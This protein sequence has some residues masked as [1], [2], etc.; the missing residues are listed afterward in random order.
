[1]VEESIHVLFDESNP[2]PSGKEDVVDDDVGMLE[3][4]IQKLNIEDE[5]ELMEKKE[6][7]DE[8][9]HQ[10]EV[11]QEEAQPQSQ[12]AQEEREARFPRLRNHVDQGEI[13]GNPHD[14]VRT[15]SFSQNYMNHVAF[16]SHI[17][18]MNVEEAFLDIVKRKA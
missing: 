13:I 14:G 15:R 8:V 17:E 12:Q 9:E 3:N 10:E 5:D 16:I 11:H 18:P 7:D 2:S 1:M 4:N 6:E